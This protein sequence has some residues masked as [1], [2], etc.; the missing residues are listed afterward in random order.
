MMDAKRVEKV[1]KG[2][3]CCAD[4]GNCDPCPYTRGL[5]EV[6]CIQDMEK[7]A[8]SVIRE[9]KAENERLKQG[10]ADVIERIKRMLEEIPY[11]P[12]A[13]GV[14]LSGKYWGIKDALD[15]INKPTK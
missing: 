10:K 14:Y 4:P 11:A 13:D 1:C 3:E 5:E 9:L 7:D 2:L 12:A 15:I 8:L 6:G